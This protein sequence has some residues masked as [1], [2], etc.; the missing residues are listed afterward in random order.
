MAATAS[1]SAASS[2]PGRVERSRKTLGNLPIKLKFDRPRVAH[3]RYVDGELV[4]C[5]RGNKLPNRVVTVAWNLDI[6]SNTLIYGATVYKKVSSTDHWHKRIHRERAIS[7]YAV[8]PVLIP[9]KNDTNDITNMA[10]ERYI[11]DKLIYRFTCF[12]N[13]TTA[14]FEP[15]FNVSA[16]YDIHYWDDYTEDSGET[17]GDNDT[18]QEHEDRRANCS[19]CT[20][21][22][23]VL[24]PIGVMFIIT[25]VRLY[26]SP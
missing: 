19:N 20:G 22:W 3:I 11:A 26:F 13:T 14:E 25:G 12:D 10:M 24:V 1:A 23:E 21:G 8:Q 5:A 2:N 17:V 6:N 4:R 7:R 18:N 9:F 15:G 16:E